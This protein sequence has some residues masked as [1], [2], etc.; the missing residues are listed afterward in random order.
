MAKIKPL[1]E[2]AILENLEYSE[3]SASG[4]VWKI[5]K[6][7]EVLKALVQGVC[8]ETVTGMFRYKV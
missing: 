6:E 7:V 1:P 8:V 3:A 4:L 5:T 2:Q